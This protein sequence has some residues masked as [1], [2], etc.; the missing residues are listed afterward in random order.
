MASSTFSWPNIPHIPR[1]QPSFSNSLI[2]NQSSSEP[3]PQV[4]KPKASPQL[5]RWSRARALRSGHKL[6]RHTNRAAQA[7][8]LRSPDSPIDRASPEPAFKGRDGDDDVERT[9]GK[10]IYMVSDGTGWT[11]EHSVTA[12]LGQ[13]THCLV[14]RV[15]PVNTH[16]FSGVIL[17][18]FVSL[19]ILFE[20]LT[21]FCDNWELLCIG[22]FCFVRG[23]LFVVCSAM[24]HCNFSQFIY[25]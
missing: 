10:S 22:I 11:V 9:V 15:C 19:F 16:L 24:G 23:L 17:D 5:N 18:F 1:I 4:R 21:L 3:G 12:A 8:D 20:V 14:D 2:Y 7:V 25:D 13:F 6:E